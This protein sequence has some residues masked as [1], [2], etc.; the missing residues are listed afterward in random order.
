[1]P[2]TIHT[3]VRPARPTG[4]HYGTTWRAVQAAL[5][6]DAYELLITGQGIEIGRA[7]V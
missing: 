7:H 5:V 2:A 1:M 4:E 6:N 3:A